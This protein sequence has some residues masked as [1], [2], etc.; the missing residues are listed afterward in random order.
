MLRSRIAEKKA[1]KQESKQ[2]N[3]IAPSVDAY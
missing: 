1:G 2:D 3:D